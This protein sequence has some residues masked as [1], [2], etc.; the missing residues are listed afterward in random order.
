MAFND[1]FVFMLKNILFRLLDDIQIRN[2][3]LAQNL[4]ILNGTSDFPASPLKD[5]DNRYLI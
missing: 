3:T 5:F 1:S 2:Q 4:S